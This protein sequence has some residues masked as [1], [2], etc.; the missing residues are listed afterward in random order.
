M[1]STSADAKWQSWLACA[2]ST[3]NI[4]LA[5]VFFPVVPFLGWLNYG[6]GGTASWLPE[7]LLSVI[8]PGS[9]ALYW[10]FWFLFA[11]PA[12]LASFYLYRRTGKRNP[13]ILIALNALT[14][15]L[16]WGVRI[17][18]SILGIRPDSV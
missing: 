8:L 9:Y 5:V 17:A 16:Y 11:I 12:L 2:L 7:F 15:L 13:R 1:K 6:H 3:V 18:F 10:R 14:I 4:L